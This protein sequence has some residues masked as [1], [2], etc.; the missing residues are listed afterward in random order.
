MFSLSCPYLNPKIS[1]TDTILLMTKALIIDGGR[2]SEVSL[3]LKKAC[4]NF[5]LRY[6]C[7]SLGG[8]PIYGCRQGKCDSV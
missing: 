4:L 5:S 7:S 2:G 3:Q 1:H 8:K 6:N